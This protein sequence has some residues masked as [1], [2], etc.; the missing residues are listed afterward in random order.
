MRPSLDTNFDIPGFI[1]K[2]IARHAKEG[3]GYSYWKNISVN[4]KGM[5]VELCAEKI[6]SA[7]AKEKTEALIGGSETFIVYFHRFF[8]ALF[9]RIIRNHPMRRLRQI[10]VKLSSMFAVIS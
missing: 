5:S 10:N 6:M 8:P 2:P 7:I 1:N 9:A 4:D 3:K